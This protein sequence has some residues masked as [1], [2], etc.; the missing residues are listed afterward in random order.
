M[1]LP[2]LYLLAIASPFKFIPTYS[3]SLRLYRPRTIQEHLMPTLNKRQCHCKLAQETVELKHESSKGTDL[4]PRCNNFH[5]TRDTE[6]G[7]QYGVPQLI[8]FLHVTLEDRNVLS[9]RSP[10]H[11]YTALSFLTY[12]L[13]HFRSGCHC[14]TS[15]D[16]YLKMSLHKRDSLDI[17]TD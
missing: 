5:D 8:K 3:S 17:H 4:L 16:E 13:D 12:S 6:N 14:T 2:I 1:F 10:A 15:D 11:V 9:V 7:S